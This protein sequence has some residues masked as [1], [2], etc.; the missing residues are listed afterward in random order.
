M[1]FVTLLAI[2][3]VLAGCASFQRQ[4]PD[5]LLPPPSIRA[6]AAPQ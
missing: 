5:N 1:K 4:T 2:A 3:I 6:P